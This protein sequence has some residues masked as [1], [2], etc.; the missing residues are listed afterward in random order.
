LLGLLGGALIVLTAGGLETHLPGA[1]DEGSEARQATFVAFG[2]AATLAYFAAARLVLRAPPSRRALWIVLG[3]ALVLRLMVLAAPSFLSSDLFRYVWD[4]CVQIAGINPYRYVPADPALAFLRDAAIY[5]RIDRAG[6]AHTIYPPAAQLI[7]RA[8]SSV[9]QT[10]AAER[11]AMLGF[12][13]IAIA[14][15]LRLLAM[16]GLDRARVLIYAWNPLT[17]WE[18]AGNGH[19]DAAAIALLALAMLARLGSRGALAGIALGAAGLVKFLPLAAAPAFWRPRGVRRLDWIV[20]ASVMATMAALYAI[21]ADGAGNVLGFLP[22][23]A[24][25]EGLQ[26]GRGIYWL[27]V[28]GRIVPLPPAS[29]MLWLAFA[30]LVLVGI[31]LWMAFLRPPPPA[32]DPV[33]LARD[34]VLLG[35]IATALITPHYPWYFVWLALPSCLAPMPAAIFLSAAAVLQY[36]DPYGDRMLQFSQIYLPFLALVAATLWRRRIRR[37]VS[38][39]AAARTT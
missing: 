30:A 38:V 1:L 19:I 16:A 26:D 25:E 33:A 9:S 29:G 39:E 15:M 21:Y 10:E 31:G 14:A 11:A 2:A 8:I 4:G 18:F 32:D 7:F 6:Y 12:D 3:V 27:D 22:G 17:V 35:M 37:S 36:H 5:P 23:Y 34:V 20:P 28:L 24:A 13:L